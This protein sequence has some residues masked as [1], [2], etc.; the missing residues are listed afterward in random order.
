MSKIRQGRV[1]HTFA[2]DSL[3][4]ATAAIPLRIV[5]CLTDANS[6][7]FSRI[8]AADV[9]S[10][11]STLGFRANAPVLAKNKRGESALQIAKA[12]GMVEIQRLLDGN[13][14]YANNRRLAFEE[15]EELDLSA[16]VRGVFTRPEVWEEGEE[17]GMIA[18]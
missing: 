15:G 1:H 10:R 18:V 4:T 17:E 16:S 12:R 9:V 2:L 5:H 13:K 3:T 7:P 11:I 6:S 14:S 8:G